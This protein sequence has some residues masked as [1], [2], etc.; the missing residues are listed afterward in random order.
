MTHVRQSLRAAVV[1]A[2]TG[3]PTTGARV[4]TGRV[5]PLQEADLPGL[6]VNTVAEEAEP[7]SL[8]FSG[9][10]ARAVTV[11]VVGR[12]RATAAIADVLDAIAEEVEGALAGAVTVSG[13]Q[14]ALDYAGADIQFSGEVDQ[15][16]GAV[17]LRFTAQLFTLASA[18]GTLVQT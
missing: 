2:V 13:V 11:E 16:V 18:P 14:V 6:E 3:L 5:Y 8:S 4:R 9:V 17:A 1:A 15:P 7:Q 12:A 10:L